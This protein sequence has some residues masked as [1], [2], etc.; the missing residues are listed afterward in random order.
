M[1]GPRRAV[2][3]Y[4][5]VLSDAQVAIGWTIMVKKT[6]S[7]ASVDEMIFIS[8]WYRKKK[9]ERVLFGFSM[10]WNKNERPSHAPVIGEKWRIYASR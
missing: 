7:S 2:A 6:A 9:T 3:Y 5:V 8:T 4:A 10:E 1:T